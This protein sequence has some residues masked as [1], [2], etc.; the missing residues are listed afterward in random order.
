MFKTVGSRVWAFDAEWIPD[1]LGGRMLYHLEPDLPNQQ[2]FEVMWEKGGATP[3]DPMPYLKTVL[4]QIVS[5]V[6]VERVARGNNVKLHLL[7]LP[8]DTQDPVHT[9]EKHVVG[10]FL[11]KAGQYKP[12]GGHCTDCRPTQRPQYSPLG[13]ASYLPECS[14][15]DSLPTRRWYRRSR[16]CW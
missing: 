3:E 1:P 16:H 14:S 5:I 4:C 7:S 6:A 11:G 9:D 8:R 15:Q 13:L 2:V 10:T 12:H